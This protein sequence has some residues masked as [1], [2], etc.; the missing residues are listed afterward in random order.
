MQLCNCT[1]QLNVS[2]LTDL[3]A[4]IDPFLV[5]GGIWSD[6]E[7]TTASAVILA[8]PEV[9]GVLLDRCFRAETNDYSKEAITLTEEQAEAMRNGFEI[10]AMLQDPSLTAIER[11]LLRIELKQIGRSVRGDE[12]PGIYLA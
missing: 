10:Q 6:S 1:R 8:N 9:I 12:D 11:Q 5:R 4:D 3:E 2:F 7:V